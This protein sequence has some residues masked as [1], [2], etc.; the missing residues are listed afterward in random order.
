MDVSS[1][2]SQRHISHWYQ[3]DDSGITCNLDCLG[4]RH[5]PGTQA[6][7]EGKQSHG[8]RAWWMGIGQPCA[9]FMWLVLTGTNDLWRQCLFL[10]LKVLSVWVD[11][12]LCLSLLRPPDKI[13]GNIQ[14]HVEW[15]YSLWIRFYVG[16]GWWLHSEFQELKI[17]QN[18]TSELY[19]P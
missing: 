13:T 3:V 7:A 1:D 17:I 11:Y 10:H 9:F 2:T 6:A 18:Q 16:L 14:E 4:F 12:N 8:V 19:S 5:S 15:I